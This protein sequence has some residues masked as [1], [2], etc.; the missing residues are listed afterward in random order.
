MDKLIAGLVI[1]AV[2]VFLFGMLFAE[3][4]YAL[5]SLALSL[6]MMGVVVVLYRLRGK[7]RQN[8]PGNSAP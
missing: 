4:R 1:A 7:A 5:P 8:A 2:A 3:S 6:I